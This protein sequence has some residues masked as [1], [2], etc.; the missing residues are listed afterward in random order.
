MN[1]RIKGASILVT[2]ANGGIGI[3]TVQILVQ[4][5]AS[6][7]VMACRTK[8]KAEQAL[9]KIKNP[10]GVKIEAMGGFDMTNE[11]SI[12]HA[13]QKMKQGAKFDIVFLQAGGMVV[14]DDY[15]FIEANGHR[16]ERTVYQ[17]TFG[18]YLTIKEL[19]QRLLLKEDARIVFAGGE[20]A[21][22]IKGL[23]DQP[24]FKL[25][26]ELEE[27]LHNGMGKYNALNAIGVSKFF[28]AL[29]VQKLAEID[30]KR[31]YIWFSPG[32]TGGTKG[33]AEV[34]QPKRFIME[35]I[36]F[37]LM[38]FFG[39]AQSPKKAARK[40]VDSLKG[41]YGS[42]GD[43]IGAPEGK[44]L[45]KLVDQK[46]MYAGLTNYQFQEICWNIVTKTCGYFLTEIKLE[47]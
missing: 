23:I 41:I 35:K 40:Y 24:E 43:L 34:P 38:Q 7:V 10:G 12:H 6:R 18:G 8:K 1:D 3:E 31:E 36:G 15:Q 2:G 28:S 27:Y 21:R 14:A 44:A 19:N 17:N 42:S 46:P 22:G 39:L 37:P 45:G 9:R 4:E 11:K 20:G 32:L 33:L 29:L 25:T 47:T 13:V 16:I 30:E 5:G 26:H